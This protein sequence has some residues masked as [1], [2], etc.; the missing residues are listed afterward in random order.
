MIITWRGE[1]S[2]I[3]GVADPCAKTDE[4]EQWTD[5]LTTDENNKQTTKRM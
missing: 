4:R 3:F 1:S 5:A 2:V